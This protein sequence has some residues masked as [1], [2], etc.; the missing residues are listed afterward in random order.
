MITFILRA[1]ALFG[2]ALL[3]F[4]ASMQLDVVESSVPVGTEFKVE[5]AISG[6]SIA[7]A[8]AIDSLDRLAD[9]HNLQIDKIVPD[10]ADYLHGRS[11]YRFGSNAPTFPEP[12]RWYDPGWHGLIASSAALQTASLDGS[13]AVSGDPVGIGALRDWATQNAVPIS[14]LPQ[15]SWLAMTMSA[16]TY[17]GAYGAL[18]AIALMLIAAIVTW[19]ASRAR[20]T[21]L[22]MLAGATTH[23]IRADDLTRIGATAVLAAVA[24]GIASSGV[25]WVRSG[26]EY[27]VPYLQVYGPLAFALATLFLA[28]AVL[29]SVVS[30]PSVAQLASR[31]SPLK[32]FRV[33]SEAINALLLVCAALFLPVAIHTIN[34]GVEATASASR[35]AVLK[36]HLSINNFGAT[37]TDSNDAAFREVVNEADMDGHVALAFEQPRLTGLDGQS[38]V[39][40]PFDGVYYANP[41][42]LELFGISMDPNSVGPHLT[43]ATS[44]DV[45]AALRSAYGAT[46]QLQLAEPDSFD[47]TTWAPYEIYTYVSD[48]GGKFPGLVFENSAR[49]TDFAN[50][51]VILIRTPGRTMSAGFLAAAT[52]RTGVLF[53]SR[54]DL[55]TL[56]A[57]HGLADKAT[58]IDR[59]ADTGLVQLQLVTRTLYFQVVAAVIFLAALG[60]SCWLSASTW[61]AS[62]A[63]TLIP[64]RV[65]GLSWARILRRRLSWELVL[66][67]ALTA[68]VA[69]AA[70]T[71]TG[72]TVGWALFIPLGYGLLT[73]LLHVAHVRRVFHRT[74]G[75][76][77]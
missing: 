33:V 26:M 62:R 47:A 65:S 17:S 71:G 32:N 75:R 58:S 34:D 38:V 46:L 25:V 44:D 67:A 72:G 12:L 6:S 31:I 29:I 63:R 59:A 73:T 66:A 19:Y 7:K 39:T 61:A 23:Q 9:E 41:A 48:E 27:V 3:G 49:M 18:L 22:K 70:I 21:S 69:S 11:L 51:L 42:Y 14:V 50:P 2:F 68:F 10:P 1:T 77:A 43:P 13:Y 37:G 16:L 36:D 24:C 4:I 15:P 28:T 76:G 20:G 74:I 57:A 55:P 5:L 54:E 64:L 45:P 30:W 35:W 8:A 60:F 56:L 40:A 52:S 53:D